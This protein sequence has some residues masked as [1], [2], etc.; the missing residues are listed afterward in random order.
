MLC[1]ACIPN[2]QVPETVLCIMRRYF[3]MDNFQKRKVEYQLKY[4]KTGD[5][6][7]RKNVRLLFCAE[8]QTCM[9]KIQ[10]F[11]NRGEYHNPYA[12]I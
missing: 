2:V 10:S 6:I 12:K 11:G 7:L 4:I 3:G 9:F 5:S 8:H 1:L